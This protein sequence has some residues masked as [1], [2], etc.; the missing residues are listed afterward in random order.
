M[1]EEGDEGDGAN[2]V[3]QEVNS[4]ERRV[5]GTRRPAE[6]GWGGGGGVGNGAAGR[7]IKIGWTTSEIR[8]QRGEFGR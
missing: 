3:A 7:R 1:R 8:R 5:E 4:A 6:K 2:S